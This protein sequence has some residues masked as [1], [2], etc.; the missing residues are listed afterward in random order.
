MT[1]SQAGNDQRIT[2]VQIP[3]AKSAANREWLVRIGRW[4]E[5]VTARTPTAAVYRAGTRLLQ[6]GNIQHRP[7]FEPG[8]GWQNTSVQPVSNKPHHRHA[9]VLDGC[10]KKPPRLVPVYRVTRF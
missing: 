5:T 4:S 8:G 3:M 2:K 1:K 6:G 10:T 7:Q 9:L